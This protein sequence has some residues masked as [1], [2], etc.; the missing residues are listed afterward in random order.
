M[1]ARKT[2]TKS[3]TKQTW[4][5]KKPPHMSALEAQTWDF[6]AVLYIPARAHLDGG[7]IP[8]MPTWASV[9][10]V[11]GGAHIE[12]VNLVSGNVLLVDEDG[13]NKRL[14]WNSVA[15]TIAQLSGIEA[16]VGNAVFV[17]KHLVRKVLG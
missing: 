4:P 17:P 3:K 9:T 8:I 16:I 11:M 5:T 6:G 1:A 7:V 12:V 15:S 10:Y 14:A 13:L 2:I